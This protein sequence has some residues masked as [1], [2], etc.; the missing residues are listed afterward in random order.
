MWIWQL[1]KSSGGNLDRV[2]ATA[3]QYGVR[4]VYVKSSDGQYFWRQF[5]PAMIAGMRARGLKV[6]A[7]QYV[8]G[9]LPATEAALGARAAK[10]ADC[11]IIDAESEYEGRYAA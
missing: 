8:Y 5:T 1:P 4:T 10:M 6:C 9:D 7:W 2:G 3:A 11:L